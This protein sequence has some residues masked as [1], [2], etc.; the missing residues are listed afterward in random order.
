MVPER[1]RKKSVHGRLVVYPGAAEFE[2][3]AYPPLPLAQDEA[4]YIAQLQPGSVYL[5]E[6]K[7]TAENLSHWLPHL[8]SFHFAGHAVSREHGGELLL[9]GRDQVL[10]S[11]SI[12][13]LDLSGTQFVVLSACSTAE[14]DLDIVRSPNGLVQAFLSAGARE[15]VASR[16]DV[17]SQASFTFSKNFY[18]A[19]T[20]SQDVATAVRAARHNIRSDPKTQHPFYWGAFDVFEASE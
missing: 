7:V 15:V 18:A 17:D 12:R 13:R 2:G 19:L 6:E 5:R 8:S 16:W 20:K 4:D 10:S 1:I 14:A 9:S 3:T 11:S